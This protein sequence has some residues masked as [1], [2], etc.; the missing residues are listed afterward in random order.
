MEMDPN[1]KRLLAF[2]EGVPGKGDILV[3]GGDIFDLF[4]GNKPAFQKKFSHILAAIRNLA[5]RGC[6][7]YYLE[8]NHDFHLNEVFS[9]QSGILVKTDDFYLDF[10][11][12]K[13]WISHGDMIDEEDRGYRVLRATTRHPIVR[14][15]IQVIPGDFIDGVGKWSSQQSRKYN[16]PTSAGADK[17][18]RTRKLFRSYA[19]E[20]FKQG[21]EFVLIGH[22]HMAEDF[23]LG[24]GAG[25][26][27]NL[28]FSQQQLLYGELGAED[29][30]MK[31]KS[32][33]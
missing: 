3:L 17:L 15:L 10:D 22:S 12:R 23:P 6:T 33:S 31:L 27:V 4:V 28:G 20:K 19:E 25:Q 16:N 13:I 5:Q 7:I 8:G 18:Q 11:G 14:S 24:G 9:I 32:I 30:L 26:Y 21:F 2:L 29:K 1:A